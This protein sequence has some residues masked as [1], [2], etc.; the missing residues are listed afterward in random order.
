M[1]DGML[2]SAV[3]ECAHRTTT[4]CH[5]FF[6]CSCICECSCACS[7]LPDH[8]HTHTMHTLHTIARSDLNYKYYAGS[9][10]RMNTD[11]RTETTPTP[12]S[13]QISRDRM[14]VVIFFLR[15]HKNRTILESEQNS[16]CLA[17][18]YEIWLF[19]SI[20]LFDATWMCT[21]VASMLHWRSDAK[22]VIIVIASRAGRALYCF[23][24]SFLLSDQHCACTALAYACVN[25][26]FQYYY[27]ITLFNTQLE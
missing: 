9:A 13:R 19:G 16:A 6:K 5:K 4:S 15:T 20:V 23:P 22:P 21:Y 17:A 2:I 10:L 24:V 26:I 1:D 14:R 25:K 7:V 12:Y 11:K 8:T 27:V 3:W 18:R